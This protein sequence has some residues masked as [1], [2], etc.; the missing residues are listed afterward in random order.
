M[1]SGKVTMAMNL[2]LVLLQK[3]RFLV[4]DYDEFG[5][6]DSRQNPN[7]NEREGPVLSKL[8][9]SSTTELNAKILVCSTFSKGRPKR[10][11]TP[12]HLKQNLYV[13]IK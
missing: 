11:W 5:R 7:G 8:G 2:L 3:Y 9:S 6:D 12:S 4:F 10:N 1:S 13:Q